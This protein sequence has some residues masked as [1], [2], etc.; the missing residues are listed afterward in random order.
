MCF[1]LFVTLLIVAT[2]VCHAVAG[3]RSREG[4]FSRL[5]L[6]GPTKCFSCEQDMIRRAGPEY[7]WM[8]KPSKCFDCEQQMASV[9]PYLAN[10]THGT[11]CFSCEREMATT[12]AS[13]SPPL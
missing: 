5:Y 6:S 9:D 12:A 10:L 7:A 4:F 3:N 13:S 2:V 11:K 8:G 1:K